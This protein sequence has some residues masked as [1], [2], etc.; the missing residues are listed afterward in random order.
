MPGVELM[1]IEKK[2]L[3]NYLYIKP[4]TSSLRRVERK[5]LITGKMEKIKP[6]VKNISK[7]VL[8]QSLFTKV[9]GHFFPAMNSVTIGRYIPRQNRTRIHGV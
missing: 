7:R 6:T 3:Y 8:K 4:I 5:R 1:Q 9:L 2:N